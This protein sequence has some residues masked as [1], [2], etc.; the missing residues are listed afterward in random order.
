MNWQI[1]QYI[2]FANKISKINKIDKKKKLIKLR[3]ASF[4]NTETGYTYQMIVSKNYLD[5][6]YKEGQIK[7]IAPESILLTLLNKFIDNENGQ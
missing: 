7:V 4:G 1:G 2:W 5:K 6:I 3:N